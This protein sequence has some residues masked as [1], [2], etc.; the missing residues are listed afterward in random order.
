MSLYGAM[1]AGVSG[2]SAQSTNLSTISDNIANLN[3]TAYK[4]TTA[5][6]STLVTGAGNQYDYSAGGVRTQ[7]RPLVDQQGVLQASQNPTDVAILGNGFFV[8]N[9]AAAG[10]PTGEQLYTRAGAF[11]EDSTGH[12]VN[13]AGYFLQG[14]ALDQ[15]GNIS[16]VNQIQTVSVGTLNGVAVNTAKVDVGINLD[17]QQTPDATALPADFSAATPNFGVLNNMANN[18]PTTNTPAFQRQIRIYDSL[19]TP[20]DMNL[21]FI[22]LAPATSGQWGFTMTA[23]AT[24]VNSANMPVAGAPTGANAVVSFGTVTFNGDGSLG[25]VNMVAADTSGP[26]PVFA[27]TATDTANVAWSNGA[28]N[29]TMALNFGTVGKTDGMTQ[30]ASA[31]NVAFTN[32]DGAPVGLRTGVFI[33]QDGFVTATFSN[34]AVRKI[35]QL[36]IATFADPN[37]LKARNGNAYQQTTQSGEFNL[38]VANTGGAGQIQPSS[39]EGSNVDLGQEFT[40]MIVT[41]RAYSANA[42][43]I[44][45]AD[46]MLQELMQIKR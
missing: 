44:T 2:L 7:A 27:A 19:G 12:L 37:A 25:A 30:F 29:S 16:N 8:V 5:D 23:P 43:T 3:T 26:P 42:K 22:K 9:T 32:Q 10:T 33:D 4:R 17:S 6:F 34:G 36:P 24:D 18:N 38:R 41:Q 14:W 11:S 1:I 15:S 28:N 35:Y 45:T 46:E 20:H 13:S 21:S 31:Y 39:L 40:N